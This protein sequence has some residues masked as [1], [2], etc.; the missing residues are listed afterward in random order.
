MHWIGVQ[1]SLTST[2]T[3]GFCR[4][5][6]EADV[7]TLSLSLSV[8]GTTVCTFGFACDRGHP[9]LSSL[10]VECKMVRSIYNMLRSLC[11]MKSQAGAFLHIETFVQFICCYV[12]LKQRFVITKVA[13]NSKFNVWFLSMAD[14]AMAISTC[15]IQ[16]YVF[17]ASGLDFIPH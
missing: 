16:C 6:K 10:K 14:C 15:S 3:T 1:T 11:R 4:A 17:V 9:Y 5:K 8:V 12:G 2:N 7:I 13:L